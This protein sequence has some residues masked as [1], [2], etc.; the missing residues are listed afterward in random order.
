MS[1]VSKE[2]NNLNI[3]KKYLFFE[4]ATSRDIYLPAGEWLDGN[5]GEMYRNTEGIWLRNYT[6]P[7]TVLP[8]FIRQ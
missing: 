3:I 2:Q 5:T 6:A 8:Y 4:G 1:K 7:L